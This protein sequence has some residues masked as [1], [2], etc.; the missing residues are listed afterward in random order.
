MSY[1]SAQREHRVEPLLTMTG[2][3][4]SGHRRDWGLGTPS[5]QAVSGVHSLISGFSM[6]PGTS[7]KGAVQVENPQEPEP[8]QDTGTESPVLVMKSQYW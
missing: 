3:M 5:Y 6:E 2:R 7:T 8:M 1:L 4:K